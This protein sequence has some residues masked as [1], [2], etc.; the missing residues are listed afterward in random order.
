MDGEAY[1]IATTESGAV[2]NDPSEDLLYELFLDIDR[3]DET[4]FIVERVSDPTGQTYGQTTRNEDGRWIV[5]RREGGPDSHFTTSFDNLS[6]AH[7]VLFAW[8][9]GHDPDLIERTEWTR[10]AF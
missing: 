1:L 10:C 7:E 9:N 6:S 8:A 3:G 5:D 4:F 2:W